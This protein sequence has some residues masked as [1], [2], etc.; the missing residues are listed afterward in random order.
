MLLCFPVSS[1]VPASYV[2]ILGGTSRSLSSQF[3]MAATSTK[4]E[5]KLFHRRLSAILSIFSVIKKNSTVQRQ[6]VDMSYLCF[7]HANYPVAC[8]YMLLT[9]L[10]TAID[11]RLA[12]TLTCNWNAVNSIV[13]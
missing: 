6:A 2:N 5:R 13:T 12:F 1:K 4:T 7:L 9:M 8:C 10:R 11:A 3:H